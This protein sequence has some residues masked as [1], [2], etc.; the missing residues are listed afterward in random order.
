[1]PPSRLLRRGWLADGSH[2]NSVGL[3]H[4]GSEIG[5]DIVNDAVVIVE[6]RASALVD[7]PAGARELADTKPADVVEL[8]ELLAATRLGRRDPYQLTLYKAVGVAVEDAAAAALVYAA[9]RERGAG[10]T[11]AL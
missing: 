4:A 3:N 8:G 1:M 10:Q 5:A 9:A 2:A 7:P 6:S 11:V